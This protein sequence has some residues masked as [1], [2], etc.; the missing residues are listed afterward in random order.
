MKPKD[1]R[2]IDTSTPPTTWDIAYGAAHAFDGALILGNP[3]TVRPGV[4]PKV[5]E[6]YTYLVKSIP[7]SGM[8]D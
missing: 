7:F 1:F 3:L 5:P 4:W 2:R 6:G 8:K